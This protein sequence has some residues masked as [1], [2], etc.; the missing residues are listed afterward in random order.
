M[1]APSI[2]M[3]WQHSDMFDIFPIPTPQLVKRP[4]RSRSLAGARWRMTTA[5]LTAL[6]FAM[7]LVTAASHHHATSLEDRDCSVCST[8]V[9]QVPG[10]PATP[11]IGQVVS[12]LLY[13]IDVA[14]SH[15]AAYAS[16]SLLPPSCGPPQLS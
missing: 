9:H 4:H 16:S 6:T 12:A 5:F 11:V 3:A 10:A 2:Q 7:L 8:A 14:T 15:N 13:K 1:I